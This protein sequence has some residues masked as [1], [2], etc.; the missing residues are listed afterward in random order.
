M[1]ILMK[2]IQKEEEE[3]LII[4]DLNARTGNKEESVTEEENE[5]RN[6]SRKSLDKIINIEDRRLIEEE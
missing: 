4:G 5:K 6:K 3:Y 2:H 1:E